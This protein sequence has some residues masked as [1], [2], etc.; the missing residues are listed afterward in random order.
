[1]LP[2]R[3]AQGKEGPRVEVPGEVVPSRMAPVKLLPERTALSEEEMRDEGLGAV[4]PSVVVP[5]KVPPKMAALGREGLRGSPEEVLLK[6][7]ASS[8]EVSRMEVLEEGALMKLFLIK[9]P[10]GAVQIRV[11]LEGAVSQL[12]LLGVLVWPLFGAE[13]PLHPKAGL[14]RYR[15]L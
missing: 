3:A 1:M 6:R 15:S 11:R 14:S 10:P 8:K 12:V 13:L 2:E 9:E 7:A 5:L 4:V